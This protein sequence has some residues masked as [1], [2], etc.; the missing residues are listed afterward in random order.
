[1]KI[2]ILV[3]L[4]GVERYVEQCA[5][6]LFEQSFESVEFIFVD[7]CSPDRSAEIV[8]KVLEDYPHQQ[9]RTHILRN[10]VNMGVSATRNRALECAT[11]HFVLFVDG[12]DW[13]STDI[14]EELAIEQM[15]SNNDVVTSG[16]Y[17]CDGE[18]QKL[19][20]ARLKGGR[21][22]T[23]K[24]LV[25]QSFAYP[26]RIWGV[27]IR[28]DLL[29]RNSIQFE[30]RIT[31]GED[32]LFMVQLLYHASRV[33]H[34]SGGLYYY[35]SDV[36]VMRSVTTPCGEDLPGSRRSYIRA[37]TSVW[38]FLLRQPDSAK[39]SVAIRLSRMNL[40]RWLMLRKS[41]SW[42]IGSTTFRL[43]C[44]TRNSIYQLWCIASRLARVWLQKSPDQ[45]NNTRTL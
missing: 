29:V 34:Y 31:M 39:Y 9:E 13:V 10:D 40:R 5:R 17:R 15:V 3:P 44:H 4:Y 30:P 16:F 1:M 7:D 11:G 22:G 42:S 33:S 41:R 21:M 38:S 35:R 19:V 8:A 2:S 6:S 32:L 14:V 37:V 20:R 23:L 25:T 18:R 45:T 27:L 26:N 43:W 24:L 12:D 36:G 28:R